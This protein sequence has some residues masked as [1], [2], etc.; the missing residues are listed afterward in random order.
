M[1]PYQGT[2]IVTLFFFLFLVFSIVTLSQSIHALDTVRFAIMGDR[3]SGHVEGVYGKV[4]EEVER[5][6]PEIILSVGDYIEGHTEDSTVL[7]ERWQEFKKIISIATSPFYFVPGNNDIEFDIQE[8]LFE[9]YASKTYYSF[10]YKYIH[11]IMVDNSRWENWGQMPAEQM[12]WLE[13]DLKAHADAAY[14]MVFM[15]KPFWY[16]TL[17]AG[18]GDLGHDLFVRYG[19]DAV[20][21]GHFHTYFAGEYDGIKYTTIGSSGGGMMPG[22]S[23][24]GYQ[25]GWVT[26]D[27]DGIHIVTI[28]H[29]A[30]RAWDDVRAD[31]LRLKNTMELL[32]CVNTKLMVSDDNEI[33]EQT[34]DVTIRNYSGQYPLADTLTWNAPD[35]WTIT[36][37]SSEL[38]IAPGESQTLTFT[39]SAAENVFA[40]PTAQYKFPTREN[41]TITGNHSLMYA[42]QAYASKAKSIKIDG[43]ID[44][45]CWQSPSN[46]FLKYDGTESKTDSTAFYFAWDKN[47]LYLAARCFDSDMSQ[48]AANTTEQDGPVYSEDCVGYFIQIDP[49]KPEVYQMYFS[50]NGVVFDQIHRKGSDGYYASDRSWNGTYEIK[51]SKLDN[52]WI[53]EIAIPLSQFGVKLSNDNE[54]ELNFRRKQFRTHENGD[55]QIPIDSNPKTFGILHLR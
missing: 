3:T 14:T 43:K 50:P 31:E 42:K 23:G 9:K 25:F 22:I 29:S 27:D 33:P 2:R 30:A 24:I 41:R 4:L 5:M 19:V 10:D 26:V 38:N 6:R 18:E 39:A 20:F 54:I 37:M 28:D 1:K 12:K 7:D 40:I 34:F 17:S 16:R 8:R 47:N 52:A 36:P 11:F 32:G 35:G 44:E 21:C 51:T 48:L 15:H 49:T 13:D 55:W 53:I 46:D 45:S